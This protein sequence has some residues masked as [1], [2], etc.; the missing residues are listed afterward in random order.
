MVLEMV[1]NNLMNLS[2]YGNI[3]TTCRLMLADNDEMGTTDVGNVNKESIFNVWHGKK[4]QDARDIHL[5]K[6]GVEKLSPCKWCMYPRKTTEEKT[7][8]N[9]KLITLKNMSNRSQEIGK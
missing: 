7:K 9:D 8:V 3:K 1:E 4:L 5:K 6:M 2:D